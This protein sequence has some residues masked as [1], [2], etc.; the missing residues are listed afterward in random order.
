MACRSQQGPSAHLAPDNPLLPV[1]SR[2]SEGQ[3]ASVICPR[4]P[5][6]RIHQDWRPPRDGQ[7]MVSWQRW[8][9][10][11]SG[12]RVGVTL[13]PAVTPCHKLSGF[14][15]LKLY[16]CG[17]GECEMGF[18]RP[19]RKRQPRRLLLEAPGSTRFLSSRVASPPA[20]HIRSPPLLSRLLGSDPPPPPPLPPSC[21]DPCDQVGFARVLQACVLLNPVCK[22]L[23]PCRVTDDMFTGSED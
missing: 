2:A 7:A 3:K 17:G 19:E 23:W 11:G 20:P 12:C 6:V 14:R 21:K 22:A 8:C 5:R 1:L 16:S 13:A 18:T 15:Q 4:S 9:G 10:L